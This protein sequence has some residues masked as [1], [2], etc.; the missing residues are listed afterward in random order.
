MSIT[1]APDALE[2]FAADILVAGGFNAEESIVC[3]RYLVR[4]DLAGVESHGVT[5]VVEY[6]HFR[7]RG[8][9]VAGAVPSVLAPAPASC[10]MDG[11]YALGQIAMPALLE[12]LYPKASAAGTATGTLRR[13]GHIGRLADW[14]QD[15]AEQGFAAMVFA[16]DNGVFVCTAPPGGKRSVTS[17]NPVAFAIP[18][19]GAPFV[20]DM[21]TSAV[22][23]NKMRMAHKMG[24]KAPPEAI[25]D[26]QGRPTRDPAV[27]FADPPGALRAMGGDAQGHRGFGL[28]MVVDMLTAGLSGGFA[29]PAPEGEMMSQNILVTLWN[30]EAFSGFDHMARQA[31]EYMD[32][33]RATPPINPDEPVRIPGERAAMTAKRQQEQ[34]VTLTSATWA[35]LTQRAERL[36]VLAPKPVA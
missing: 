3:A 19:R 27:L 15:A 29:P 5:R 6:V 16:Q 13:C 20:L 33:L 12:R 11:H 31:Q 4:S 35:R 2:S 34:G 10:A 1:I 21:S 22:A 23:V 36:G 9:L 17:T 26:A 8:E 7:A 30:P 18:T 32:H 28:S 24:L 14:A 25:Q